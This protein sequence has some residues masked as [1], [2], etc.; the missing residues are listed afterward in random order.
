MS[1]NRQ[2]VSI[3]VL[4]IDTSTT[5]TQ[6]KDGAMQELH[7]LRY[8]GG[9]WRDIKPFLEKNRVRLQKTPNLITVSPDGTVTSE[10]PITMPL[11]VVQATW[12][13]VDG[14]HS[15]T[16][17]T[18]IPQGET[19]AQIE[20]KYDILTGISISSPAGTDP[21]YVHFSQ[22]EEVP[23]TL[24]NEQLNPNLIDSVYQ[25][26]ADD[27]NVYLILA[28]S[29]DDGPI[30]IHR[31]RI[32]EN[33]V[34]IL[35][36]L[37]FYD[38]YSSPSASFFG[39]VL[40]FIDPLEKG[41]VYF[42]LNNEEYKRFEIPSP[43]IVKQ[44]TSLTV[45]IDEDMGGTINKSTFILPRQ[46]ESMRF[47]G[48]TEVVD[49]EDED[50][51]TETVVTEKSFAAVPLYNPQ[52]KVFEIPQLLNNRY[53]WGEI[54][55]FAIFQMENGELLSPGALNISASEPF[56]HGQIAFKE[57]NAS[58]GM[59]LMLP[60]SL[61]FGKIYK[62]DDYSL[63][64][65]NSDKYSDDAVYPWSFGISPH[66]IIEL[67]E[68][69]N[70][71][72]IKSV[73]IYST[74]IFPIWDIEAL[75]SL[76]DRCKREI[77]NKE[78]GN[79]YSE[80]KNTQAYFADNKLPEQP[81]Y[82][83]KNIP[84]NEFAEDGTY[85]MHITANML[86]NIEQKTVYQSVDAHAIIFENTKEYNNRLHTIGSITTQLFRGFS[87]EWN[88][89]W[90]EMN[91]SAT[92]E[93]LIGDVTYHVRA[94]G[95]GKI[96]SDL[97][98]NKILSYPDYRAK[99]IYSPSSHEQVRF[100]L[101]EAL[102][103]N[104]A[105]A[106]NMESVGNAQDFDT[107]AEYEEISY[108]KYSAYFNDIKEEVDYNNVLWGKGNYSRSNVMRVSAPNN[109]FV[110]PLANTYAIGT[111]DNE[112]IAV[113][114]AA[115]ELSDTK[116]GEFPLYVFTKEGI[117]V[118]RV[119]SGDVL[120][121]FSLPRFYDQAINP[122]TLAVNANLL[123]IT[124]RG[125][126]ALHSSGTSLISEALNDQFNVPELDFWKTA[127]LTHQPK[128]EEVIVYN[129]D[130]D[131]N[132][133][134]KWPDAYVFSLGNRTW[135]T[136]SWIAGTEKQFQM[137]TGNIV[138]IDDFFKVLDHN[139]E[140]RPGGA[141]TPIRLISRPVKFGSMEFKRLETLIPRIEA[142]AAQPLLIK[143]EASADLVSWITLRES[144]ALTSNHTLTIRRTPCS[145]RYFRIVLEVD[146]TSNFA[147]SGFDTEYYLRFL[148]KLR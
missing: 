80:I 25:H 109:P 26:P 39:N 9:A 53:F 33:S 14:A 119:G 133:N 139:E 42:Y 6:I 72:F 94:S 60:P 54:C 48:V 135:S 84:L 93:L 103:N 28:R 73:Q 124:S 65:S 46:S 127:K 50:G 19:T 88:S 10:H 43:P 147:L 76:C 142:D 111:E 97:I 122:D 137:N 29:A 107:S 66:V 51:G 125:L 121:D 56:Y 27:E 16:T 91:T 134:A 105:Y 36:T 75:E 67:P 120:Y 18:S 11:I 146:V 35:Q 95:V 59:T 144:S 7:N 86:E 112:I 114:S 45:P 106:V 115:I 57:G 129:L 40:M 74:R 58:E 145:A 47:Y 116:I 17:S 52:N 31:V 77:E 44:T 49:R 117:W 12:I 131:D 98:A 61:I 90:S 138:L 55:F 118:M 85:S 62:S 92:T 13:D 70:R 123:Y 21:N 2:R 63:I 148:H 15:T 101:K 3:P 8:L 87:K 32:N 99:Y 140:V 38:R 5:N 89:G 64:I 128:Y 82:L 143:L 126:H 4:G 132:G 83:M 24:T 113:N 41:M 130:K 102:E 79:M 110:F 68:G 141:I 108:V 71:D 104:F 20:V 78:Y 69:V 81:F 23:N 30:Y 34:E 96:S 100:T 1:N 22:F 136:R 37:D